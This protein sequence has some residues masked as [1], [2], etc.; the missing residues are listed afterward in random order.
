MVLNEIMDIF[1]D[2]KIDGYQVR[3]KETGIEIKF[4]GKTEKEIFELIV[5]MLQKKPTPG[6]T[7][8]LIEQLSVQFPR[9]KVISIVQDLRDNGIITDYTLRELLKRKSAPQYLFWSR[10]EFAQLG[11]SAIALQNKWASTSLGIIGDGHLVELIE[12]K[13][14]LSGLVRIEQLARPAQALEETK[15]GKLLEQDLLICA[16]DDWHPYQLDQINRRALANNR[17]WLLIRGMDGLSASVGPLFMGKDTGCYHCLSSRRKSHLEHVNQFEHYEA[18]LTEQRIAAKSQG[19]PMPAYDVI[20]SLAILELMKFR[21]DFAVPVTY[22]NMVTFDL[23]DMETAIHP[24][25]KAPVCPVCKPE[26]EHASAPW[27]EPL[28]IYN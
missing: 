20:A 17:P 25:L 8:V 26:L 16:Y 7:E 6:G 3:N 28:I 1:P 19:A 24:F 22:G 15:L 10:V 2:E 9:E 12:Q 27:L 13:A 5:Q 23:Y 14:R 21:L 4:E 18:Y 11:E